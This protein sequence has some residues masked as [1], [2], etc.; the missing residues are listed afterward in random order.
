MSTKMQQLRTIQAGQAPASLEP[1]Q[2]ALDLTNGNCWFGDDS[3][4]PVLLASKTFVGNGAPP[5]VNKLES[6][7]WFKPNTQELYFF[8]NG[9]WKPV[10]VSTLDGKIT[11][12]F[13]VRN[14][15][16]T[17]DVFKV[18]GDNRTVT[19]NA[20]QAIFGSLSLLPDPSPGSPAGSG[21]FNIQGDLT[22]KGNLLEALLVPA[23]SIQMYAG[24]LTSDPDG[25]LICD[26]RTLVRTSYPDLFA[27]IGTLYNTGGENST[28]FRLPDL[29]GLFPRFHD[30]G[31]GDEW[32]DP[33]RNDREA[34]D[35]SVVGNVV[36]TLQRD[37]MQEHIHLNS[38]DSGEQ[39]NETRGTD[40]VFDPNNDDLRQS[41]LPVD[42][43][44]VD[45]DNPDYVR[46][47]TENRPRNI[48]LAGIIKI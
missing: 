42:P 19:T 12:D 16:D 38:K 15:A 47:S 11:G 31:R 7:M 6:N 27:A 17:Q 24:T 41:S 29:R 44:S 8:H 21:N 4:L 14:L 45:F 39:G 32:A 46:V 37:A 23:G 2:F 36:G 33:D 43:N 30:T 13:L 48:Y 40:Q 22:Y 18:D 34:A 26:G 5:P 1:G 35:G 28:I 10:G 3:S 20:A 9:E 25:W